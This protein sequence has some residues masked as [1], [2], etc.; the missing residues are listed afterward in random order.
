M[1]ILLIQTLAARPHADHL[2]LFGSLWAC[3]V[4]RHHD[5]VQEMCPEPWKSEDKDVY[6][7]AFELV[8]ITQETR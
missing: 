1:I 7:T 2:Q 8:N 6:I 4:A 5:S 3:C